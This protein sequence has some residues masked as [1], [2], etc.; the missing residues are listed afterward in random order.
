[1]RVKDIES[2]IDHAQRL[3][4]TTQISMG[5]LSL[6][7][8][9]CRTTLTRRFKSRG[10]NIFDKT[11]LLDEIEL[12]KDPIKDYQNGMS[13]LAV[14]I[15]Y[16]FSRVLIRKWLVKEGIKIRS[17]SEANYI[18]MGKMT[19]EQRLKLTESAH[20]I[21]RT[22]TDRTQEAINRAKVGGRRVGPLEKEMKDFLISRGYQVKEQFAI[23]TYNVDLLI[24]NNIAVEVR[25][26]KNV[27]SY[28]PTKRK[29]IEYLLN[30]GYHIFCI[31]FFS[32]EVFPF[33]LENIISH[34]NSICSDPSPLRK[35]RMVSCRL[36]NYS[37]LRNERGQF[38][39][40]SSPEYL[41]YRPVESYEI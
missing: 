4:E 3:Y 11:V 21:R 25:F 16:G 28:L 38:S 9:I 2:L 12:S 29:R 15:K 22:P 33:A 5:E 26:G 6:K 13:E 34:I 37:I 40:I 8:G 14:S 7:F 24:S 18:R 17:G 19:P 30:A 36:M 39:K 31:H 41:F 27:T 20:Q 35:Y 32:I 10:I 1:M 23:H